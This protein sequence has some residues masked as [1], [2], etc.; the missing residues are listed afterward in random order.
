MADIKENI[1][2]KIVALCKRRGFIYQ[3][4]EIYGG[5]SGTWDYGPLGV[6]LKNNIRDAW[7]RF[8]VRE[9]DDMYGIDSAIL[10]NSKVWEASGHVGGFADPMVECKKCKRRFRED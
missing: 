1:M 5:L 3:G 4:P 7:W 10:M 2:E 6:E 9:R 8:F